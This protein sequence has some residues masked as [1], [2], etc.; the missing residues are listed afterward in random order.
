MAKCTPK[1]TPEERAIASIRAVVRDIDKVECLLARTEDQLG[2]PR[3]RAD[4]PWDDR[5]HRIRDASRTQ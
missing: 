5:L 3:S 4:E 1:K 2:L